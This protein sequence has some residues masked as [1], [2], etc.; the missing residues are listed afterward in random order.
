MKTFSPIAAAA[1]LILCV[2]LP[3]FGAEP[4]KVGIVAS[5]IIT[6]PGK[7]YLPTCDE[8]LKTRK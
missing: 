1:C 5:D 4:I 2:A 7:D 8:V 3:S 6:I